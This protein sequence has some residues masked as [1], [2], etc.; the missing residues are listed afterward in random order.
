MGIVLGA[1]RWA[2][3]TE[4][5]ER[6]RYPRVRAVAQYRRRGSE[7]LPL[8]NLRDLGQGGLGA[9]SWT[10]MERGELLELDLYFPDGSEFLVTARVV[11][12]EETPESQ[13]ANYN[14]GL[15]F[16]NLDDEARRKIYLYV[17]QQVEHEEVVG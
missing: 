16:V 13:T 9:Y 17:E 3:G 4:V 8:Q 11:W 14:A 12:V 1:G 2:R 6:R 15:T 10:P 7:D 5:S